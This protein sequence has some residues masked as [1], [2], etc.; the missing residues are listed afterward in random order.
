MKITHAQP[1]VQSGPDGRLAPQPLLTPAEAEAEA[2]VL[3]RDAGDMYTLVAVDDVP[4]GVLADLTER[5]L[6]AGRL[7]L[8][9][10]W[11][12]VVHGPPHGCEDYLVRVEI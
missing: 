4:S 7:S 6:A 9:T 10:H 12:G 11:L 8:Y 3:N 5:L 2:F 1:L